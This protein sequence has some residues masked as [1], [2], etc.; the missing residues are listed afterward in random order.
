MTAFLV[1]I[2][3]TKGQELSSAQS[4]GID[5]LFQLLSDHPL[6]AHWDLVLLFQLCHWLHLCFPSPGLEHQQQR[7]LHWFKFLI[8]T[9]SICVFIISLLNLLDLS[10]ASL[11]CIYSTTH[12]YTERDK[13]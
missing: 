6:L 8:N 12:N 5:V 10:V 7:L 3:K 13:K 9:V 11:T 1:C 4:P 2:S